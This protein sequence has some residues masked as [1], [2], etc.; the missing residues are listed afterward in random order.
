[1]L[2][3]NSNLISTNSF[4]AQIRLVAE[5]VLLT[6]AFLYI[7]AALRESRFLGYHMFIENLVSFLFSKVNF[8]L[9]KSCLPI[10]DCA[11]SS[12]VPVFVLS[13][14]DRAMVTFG[15]PNRTRRSCNGCDNANYS[16]IF[17]IFLSVSKRF[18]GFPGFRN[19]KFLR[20]F[21][22]KTQHQNLSQTYDC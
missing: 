11:I 10:D 20:F 6:G 19:F 16:A 8:S 12:H 13:D 4:P 5:L 9:I 17:P 14:D 22:F 7:F 15:L 2:L 1:M 3:K 21:I 18:E